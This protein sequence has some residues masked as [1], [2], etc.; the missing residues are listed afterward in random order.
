MQ[1]KTLIQITDEI[2]EMMF[3]RES[4]LEAGRDVPKE[5]ELKLTELMRFEGEKI[6][7]CVSFVRMSEKQIDW[8]DQEIE[9]L[10]NEKKKYETAIERMKEIAK[11]VMESNGIVKMEGEKGHSFRLQRSE[12]LV[13]NNL[14]KVPE[15]Y[16]RKKITLEADKV[17]LKALVKDGE[18]IP[19]VEL[20]TNYSVV[21][22]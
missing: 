1:E 20:K 16:L 18:E 4:Y 3:Q 8:L 10:K 9:H 22:K 17:A 7:K 6:D 12:S 11:F 5:I 19:G 2:R 14:D 21:I 13:V 15:K